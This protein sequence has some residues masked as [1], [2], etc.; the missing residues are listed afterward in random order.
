MF[1]SAG[2]KLRL[3]WIEDAESGS[4]PPHIEGAI[5]IALQHHKGELA[6][7]EAVRWRIGW[8]RG[9]VK[10][11]AEPASHRIVIEAEA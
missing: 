6:R 3:C 9:P 10:P 8:R 5:G 4:E 1:L 2:L 11:L 7:S